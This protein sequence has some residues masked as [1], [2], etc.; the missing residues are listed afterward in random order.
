SGAPGC[1]RWSW[2]TTS[3]RLAGRIRTA[4]GAGVVGA[5]GSAVEAGSPGR[6]NRLSDTPQAY[7]DRRSLVARV[8]GLLHASGPGRRHEVDQLLDP[9][10]QRRLQI[11][12][13]AHLTAD[14]LPGVRDV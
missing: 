12:P 1:S 5:P 14:P 3:S 11:H 2:P 8:W 4:S 9:A 13:V 7:H 6:S 10:D